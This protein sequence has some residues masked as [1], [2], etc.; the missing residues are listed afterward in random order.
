[1]SLLFV[2]NFSSRLILIVTEIVGTEVIVTEAAVTEVKAIDGPNAEYDLHIVSQTA[3]FP[4]P[5]E[6][7]T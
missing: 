3:V 7:T 6:S 4:Q 2:V 5:K 1:M